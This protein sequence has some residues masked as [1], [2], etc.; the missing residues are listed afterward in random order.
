MCKGKH[1]PSKRCRLS[2][3]SLE[4]LPTAAATTMQAGNPLPEVAR[5]YNLVTRH[6]FSSSEESGA[7]ALGEVPAELTSSVISTT[8]LINVSST[9]KLE[10]TVDIFSDEGFVTVDIS[11]DE[12]M[13]RGPCLGY[14]EEMKPSRTPTV[15]F[16]DTDLRSQITPAEMARRMEVRR[17]LALPASLRRR[18][19][20]S[21][22]TT[23][24]CNRGSSPLQTLPT[25]QEECL[26]LPRTA[27]F[28]EK[29]I[30]KFR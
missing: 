18:P 13:V 27:M 30:S 11:S 15:S 3:T 19:N 16:R 5:R 17:T 9:D 22:P 8:E 25:I 21:I 20:P 23:I 24:T 12:E 14:E 1:L 4:D 7:G 26:K 2:H 28:L 6:C 29:Y 10:I